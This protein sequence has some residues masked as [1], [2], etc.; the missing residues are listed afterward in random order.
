MPADG[1]LLE[2]AVRGGKMIFEFDNNSVSQSGNTR[3]STTARTVNQLAGDIANLLSPSGTPAAAF[4]SELASAVAA[5]AVVTVNGANFTPVV[6]FTRSGA[7][8]TVSPVA[9]VDGLLLSQLRDKVIVYFN[10][11]DP[12]QK[13][14]AENTRNYQ[15]IETNASS[16]GDVAVNVPTSVSYDAISGTAV[17]TFAATLVDNKLYRL[18]VGGSTDNNGTIQTAVNIGS[19]FQQPVS[20]TPAFS[21]AAFLGDGSEGV[22]DVD[23]YKFSLTA[24]GTITITIT[25]EASLNAVLRLFDSSGVAITTGVTVSTN[26]AGVVDTLSYLA[27]AGTFY[28]GVSSKR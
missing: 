24:P 26:G 23:L 22:N 19:V 15:L 25:P 12:L 11:N 9:I 3:V 28:G 5:S 1:D 20:A 16:G 17:L 14:S 6:K 10:P 7:V 4:G 13:T 21:T 18:Q 8:P 2:V 27:P